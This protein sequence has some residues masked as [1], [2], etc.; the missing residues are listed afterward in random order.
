MLVRFALD[1][2]YA[3]VAG[4]PAALAALEAQLHDALVTLLNC[5]SEDVVITGI[6]PGSIV[7]N[8]TV[9][10]PALAS[11]LNESLAAAPVVVGNTS[12]AVVAGSFVALAAASEAPPS[13][14]PGP[15]SSQASTTAVL[16]GAPAAVALVI[17]GI[18]AVVL[19]LRRRRHRRHR[20]PIEY[21][22]D[23]SIAGLP[24]DSRARRVSEGRSSYVVIQFS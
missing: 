20:Q 14:T 18:V 10:T 22:E 12:Y 8:A 16:V 4:S 1:A 3:T 15:A 21:H 13:T 24:A 2:D 11:Q 17:A 6:A 9:R 5:S 23:V 7:V 19:V